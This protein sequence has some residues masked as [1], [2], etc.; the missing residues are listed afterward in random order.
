MGNEL[1]RN[2]QNGAHGCHFVFIQAVG[3]I[4]GI[5]QTAIRLDILSFLLY[6]TIK[7]FS[8]KRKFFNIKKEN[9]SL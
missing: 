4:D 6:N 2:K 1:T 5:A 9:R 8:R 7:V 3:V